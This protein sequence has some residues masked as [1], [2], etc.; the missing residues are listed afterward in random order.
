MARTRPAPGEYPGSKMTGKMVV[1][2]NK[3]WTIVNVPFALPD[4]APVRWSGVFKAFV[5]DQNGEL[6]QRNIANLRAL[7]PEWNGMDLFGLEDID[8]DA[9]NEAHPDG[10]IITGDYNDY[11]K[12]GKTI[13][14][15]QIVFLNPSTG[16]VGMMPNKIEGTARKALQTKLN[17][18]LK[19]I[20][21]STA[22]GTV[23]KPAAKPA[24]TPEVKQSTLPAKTGMPARKVGSSTSATARTCTADEILGAL[25]KANPDVAQDDLATRI[26]DKLDELFPDRAP[27][28]PET[29]YTPAEWGQVATALE[30]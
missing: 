19:A 5:V 14:G 3:G 30:V 16:G 10:A 20:A 25:E 27:S 17:S 12:D 6:N 1:S 15:Y 23:A 4:N 8:P 18:K 28:Q 22:P 9:W 21:A 2:E 7:F 26:Y 29:V 13:E 11:E 24:A